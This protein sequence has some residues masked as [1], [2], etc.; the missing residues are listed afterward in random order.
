MPS[1]ELDRGKH[2]Q[3]RV[4]A[5]AVVEDLEVARHHIVG[6]HKIRRATTSPF[7]AIHG[8]TVRLRLS[9][10]RAAP[11]NVGKTTLPVTKVNVMPES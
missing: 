7:D 6:R 11:G 5:L 1:L 3:C 9:A 8:P 10:D 4:T 2:A